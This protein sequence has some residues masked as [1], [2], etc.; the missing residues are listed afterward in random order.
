MAGERQMV[1]VGHVG[2]EL[3]TRTI[4]AHK[5]TDATTAAAA[6]MANQATTTKAKDGEEAGAGTEAGAIK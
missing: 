4:Y 1:N 2:L 6:T 3:A 5:L